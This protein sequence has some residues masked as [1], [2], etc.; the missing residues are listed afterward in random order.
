MP[1]GALWMKYLDW[2]ERHL[3]LLRVLAIRG[4]M[5]EQCPRSDPNWERMLLI[6][7]SLGSV[8]VAPRA[9]RCIQII[10]GSIAQ[11]NRNLECEQSLKSHGLQT[12][13]KSQN[14]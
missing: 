5:E 7:E 6:L 10:R 12:H 4:P 9:P 11:R 8:V 3:V 2:E 14:S 13:P 1:L